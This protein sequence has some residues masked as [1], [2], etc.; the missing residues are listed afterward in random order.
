[1]EL[2]VLDLLRR[3]LEVL[4]SKSLIYILLDIVKVQSELL[5]KL[6]LLRS[7]ISWFWGHGIKREMGILRTNF[8]SNRGQSMGKVTRCPRACAPIASHLKR[9]E[10]ISL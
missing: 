2:P 8:A 5:D 10:R 4:V 7:A 3:P 6:C 9:E 1:M